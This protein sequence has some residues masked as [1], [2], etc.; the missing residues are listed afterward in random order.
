MSIDYSQMEAGQ[1][2]REFNK[3]RTE[4]CRI[5]LEFNRRREKDRHVMKKSELNWRAV[6]E[7]MLL[8]SERVSTKIAQAVNP[9]LGFNVHNFLAFFGEVPAGA[10]VGAYHTHGEAIKYYVK[11]KGRE[12]IGDKQYDV[13]EGDVVF[14]PANTWH[15]TQNV[16]DE[17]LLFFAV[18]QGFTPTL[19]QPIYQ[20]R[21]D[22]SE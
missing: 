2:F 16:S 5:E 11:G 8:K 13:Q 17:N 9:V 4:I 20:S 22:L 12:I 7:L 6:G 10:Q 19:V 18:T 15:G 21:K 3:L 14:I 1:L